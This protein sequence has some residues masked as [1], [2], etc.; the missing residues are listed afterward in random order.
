[1]EE[2]KDGWILL[3]AAF[4]GRPIFRKVIATEGMRTKFRATNSA[5][6][7]AAPPASG[8]LFAELEKLRIVSRTLGKAL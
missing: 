5:D 8:G 7:G 4:K 6:P 1:M 3:A 2:S